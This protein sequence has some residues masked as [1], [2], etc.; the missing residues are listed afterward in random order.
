MSLKSRKQFAAKR[1]LRFI[2]LN[3]YQKNLS[4]HHVDDKHVIF[5][6]KKIHNKHQHDHN[7]KSSMQQINKEAFKYLFGKKEHL[8]IPLKDARNIMLKT[9]NNSCG[10]L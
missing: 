7:D 8:K 6:P 3:T 5:V 1:G 2:N 9:V 10:I 4:A